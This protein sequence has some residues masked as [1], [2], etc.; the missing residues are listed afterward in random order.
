MMRVNRAVARVKRS[1][2]MTTF[3]TTR[4]ETALASSIRSNVIAPANGTVPV[5]RNAAIWGA[6]LGLRTIRYRLTQQ[7]CLGH[8]HTRIA[9]RIVV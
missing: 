5:A 3:S 6:L 8:R 4:P 2:Y 9:A 1:G 7:P